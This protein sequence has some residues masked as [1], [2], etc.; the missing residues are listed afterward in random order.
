VKRERKTTIVIATHNMFQAE[1]LADR[2]ALILEGQ[3]E[4]IGKILEIFALPSKTLTKFA[5]LENV[6]SGVSRISEEGCSIVDVG[7][8]LQIEAT[9][10]R[11][12]NVSVHERPED[13]ILSLQPII[14]S[15]RNNFEG[16]ITEISDV[17]S[18]VK[19][20][21]NAGKDFIVQITKRSFNEMQLNLN[22]K[23]FLSFKASA[24]Q[25][26]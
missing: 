8:R 25:L 9:M 11:L 3:I 2:V 5:R 15:A 20:K 14:S 7:D 17:G 18:I 6:F 10:P 19:L 12:G 13:I 1:T 24:V 26:I 23:I 22:S 16:R 4:K 21:I